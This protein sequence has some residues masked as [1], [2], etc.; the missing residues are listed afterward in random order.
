MLRQSDSYKLVIWI[1]PQKL[2][3]KNTSLPTQ[4]ATLFRVAFCICKFS[5]SVSPD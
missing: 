4:K 3:T 5:S 1:D 2:T